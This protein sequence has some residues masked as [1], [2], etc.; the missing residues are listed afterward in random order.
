[1]QTNC[2]EKKTHE[3]ITKN[4]QSLQNLAG[5]VCE[6][7]NFGQDEKSKPQYNSTHE[8]KYD[9]V[10]EL[11]KL[12]SSYPDLRVTVNG[13]LPQTRYGGD[14]G[15]HF[16]GLTVNQTL[17]AIFNMLIL[18]SDFGGHAYGGFVRDILVP[19]FLENK[20]E[21]SL[22]FKDVDIWFHDQNQLFC[23]LNMVNESGPYRLEENDDVTSDIQNGCYPSSLTYGQQYV[24]YFCKIKVAYVDLVASQHLPV[25]DFD[26]NLLLFIPQE[27]DLANNLSLGL[28]DSWFQVG[29]N[30][31]GDSTK[32]SVRCICEH[33]NLEQ[34]YLLSGYKNP[35]DEK[36]KSVAKYRIERLKR[37]GW[38]VLN[39]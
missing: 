33:I 14:Y 27:V 21:S 7:A 31:D 38:T 36:I 26:V 23:F 15:F 4:C 3:T 35:P 30:L 29:S 10:T 5:D 39:E 28:S 16:S 12:N 13:R 8:H 37:W 25:N 20:K 11:K 6:I 24:L 9:L 32:Y 19:R 34:A 22:E 18:A 1:M 17:K 2:S